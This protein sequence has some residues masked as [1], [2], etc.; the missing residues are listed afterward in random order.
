MGDQ[1]NGGEVFAA[2]KILKKRYKKVR[3]FLAYACLSLLLGTY[4]AFLF[5]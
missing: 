2:E 1:G 4:L 3:T 5:T